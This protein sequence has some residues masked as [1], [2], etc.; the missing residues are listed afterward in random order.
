MTDYEVVRVFCDPDGRF[1]NELG[2][3]RA[4]GGSDEQRLTVARTLGFS[5]TVF[6]DDAVRGEIDIWTPSTR[7][8]FAGHPCVG[9]AHLLG[10]TALRTRAG[11][12]RARHDGELTWIAA[13][14]DWVPPRTL[15]RYESAEEI[16]ALE[17]PPPGAWIYAW[18]WQDEA[19]GR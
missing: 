10:T 3:V 17:V 4:D 19:A 11:R 6:I 9:V 8:P 13:Q 7:L 14:P 12:V 1:G 16:A 2:I 18:A 15:R 5:E